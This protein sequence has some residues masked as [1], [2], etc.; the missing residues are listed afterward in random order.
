[1]PTLYREQRH[2]CNDYLDIDLFPVFAHARKGKRRKKAKPTSLTQEKYNHQCRVKKLERLVLENFTPGEALFYNPSYD[3]EHLPADYDEAIRSRQNFIKRLKRYR[4]KKGLP[5][6]KYIVTTE[7]G[8]RS[9]RFHHHMILNCADMSIAEL[10]ML[11][12]AGF[13]FSS[14]VMFTNDGVTGLVDYFC[15]K[16]KPTEKTEE[17]DTESGKAW[18]ASRNLRQPKETK[19][20]G[21]VSVRA[22]KELYS[23][24]NDAKAE[25]EKLYPDYNFSWAK[26]LYNE[27]NGGYYVAVRMRR[28]PNNKCKPKGAAT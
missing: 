22:A 17:E 8:K 23:L 21:R 5:E 7:Q 25:W 6:L 24:G 16:K 3:N 13:A 10:D 9:G 4:K 12:S 2:I 18:S 20:D 1:M 11:W 19:R 14:L 15:K 27:I 28:K 26:A